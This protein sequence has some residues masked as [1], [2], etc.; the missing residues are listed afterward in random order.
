MQQSL[1]SY[2]SHQ[3]L[4]VWRQTGDGLGLSMGSCCL[5]QALLVDVFAA[6]C[7]A[8]LVELVA[9]LP[10]VVAPTCFILCWHSSDLPM[11]K[12]VSCPLLFSSPFS[13]GRGAFGDSRKNGEA[14]EGQDHEGV[15]WQRTAGPL[16]CIR[17]EWVQ[18]ED[19]LPTCF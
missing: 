11:A 5:R 9:A 8:K 18:S 10:D 15:A 16:A 13:L 7:R 1:A 17:K 4:R 2:A 12:G 6:W 19:P 3:S 14:E